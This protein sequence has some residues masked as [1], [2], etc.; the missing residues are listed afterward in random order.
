MSRSG[1]KQ[2]LNLPS[3]ANL[4]VRVLLGI[5]HASLAKPI[6]WKK[7]NFSWISCT[8]LKESPYCI[9]KMF[10]AFKSSLTSSL[11]S[12]LRSELSLASKTS[13][14]FSSS[15]LYSTEV[16]PY[17]RHVVASVDLLSHC[18]ISLTSES[19]NNLLV[20]EDLL[21]S[22]IVALLD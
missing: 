9:L 6:C 4:T 3:S 12:T 8:W 22:V 5:V 18:L 11:V 10:L 2:I 15:L 16:S 19:Y 14:N 7:S 21:C 13:V 20:P 1:K 17:L